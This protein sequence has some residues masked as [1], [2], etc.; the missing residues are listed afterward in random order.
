MITDKELEAHAKKLAEENKRRVKEH[1]E[2]KAAG[3]VGHAGPTT[4]EDNDW[5]CIQDDDR[6]EGLQDG[7]A[8]PGENVEPGKS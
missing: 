3:L 1:D 7:P 2:L 5:L 4:L 8:Q 6:P